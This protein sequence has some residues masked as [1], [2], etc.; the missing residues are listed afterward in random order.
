LFRFIFVHTTAPFFQLGNYNMADYK[1]VLGYWKLRGLCQ[2]IRFLAKYIGVDLTEKIY[3]VETAEE[4][5]EKDKLSLG[6]DFPN[7]PYLITGDMKLTES[8]AIL[9]YLAREHGQAQGVHPTKNEDIRA[10]DM[11]ENVLWDIWFSLLRY[12]N[13]GLEP[14]KQTFEN[15]VPKKI[16]QLEDF[17]GSKKFL[18]GDQITYVDFI[19]YEMLFHF[20]TFQQDYLG[21]YLNLQ[22]FKQR[23]EEL[24]AI[25]EYIA[26]SDYIKG[27][28]INPFAKIK[29]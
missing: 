13:S 23:F 25:A 26:S 9:K 10:C 24:P 20:T 11:V 14:M 22:K 29:I 4:W 3:T 16:K 27:P 8:R 17:L 2:P 5:K 1:I 21:K 19:M 12:L 28:C 18:V 7:L 15:D 6:L